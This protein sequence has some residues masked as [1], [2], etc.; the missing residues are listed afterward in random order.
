MGNKGKSQS[1]PKPVARHY[2]SGETR[3][4][5]A[6]RPT[7]YTGHRPVRPAIQRLD[8]PS[9]DDVEDEQLS[10]SMYVKLF[11]FKRQRLFCAGALGY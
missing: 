6:V 9:L 4:M 2:E 11:E 3:P 10:K 7:G 1:K 8:M 5:N